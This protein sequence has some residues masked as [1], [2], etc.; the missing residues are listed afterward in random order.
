MKSLSRCEHY[1]LP[2]LEKRAPRPLRISCA[3]QCFHTMPE[4]SNQSPTRPWPCLETEASDKGV[5][6]VKVRLVKYVPHLTISL[7]TCDWELFACRKCFWSHDVPVSSGE[8]VHFG[9]L[10]VGSCKWGGV[11][12]PTKT[13]SSGQFSPTNVQPPQRPNSS[14]DWYKAASMAKKWF[15]SL[16]TAAEW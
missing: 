7:A 15:H 1:H 16:E 3:G 6:I 14:A 10:Q 5:L 2:T 8:V 9:H 12:Q 11:V 13:W 4:S